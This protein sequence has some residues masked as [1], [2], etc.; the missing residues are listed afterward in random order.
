VSTVTR[1]RTFLSTWATTYVGLLPDVPKSATLLC[2]HFVFALWLSVFRNRRWGV[3]VSQLQRWIEFKGKCRNLI[4]FVVL[5][6][7]ETWSLALREERRLRVFENR[8]LR[9][10]FWPKRFEVP[11]EQE[12]VGNSIVRS[13]VICTVQQLL[14]LGWS[15]EGGRYGLGSGTWGERK[16]VYRVWWGNL[17]ERD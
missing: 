7:C 17:R 6:G 12:A 3:S 10:T 15:S 16:G 8:G 13:F 11:G 2:S 5:Y 14:L 9:R 1:V 4:L